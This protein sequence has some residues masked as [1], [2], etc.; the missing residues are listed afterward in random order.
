MRSKPLLKGLSL[1][2]SQAHLLECDNCVTSREYRSLNSSSLAMAQEGTSISDIDKWIEKLYTC[3]ILEEKEVKQL[4][5]KAKEILSKESNVIEVNSPIT[6]CGDLFGH[7]HDLL[8]VFKTGGK[9]PDTNYLFL[10]N[11]IDRGTH[12]VETV[13]LL[14]ALKIKHPDRVNLLRGNHECRQISKVYGLYDECV[15]KYGNGNVWN[16]FMDLF[17]HF[18]LTALIEGRILGVHGGLSPSIETLDE[19]RDLN[20]VQDVPVEGPICDLLWSDPGEHEG[21]V[22]SARGAGHSFGADIT[23]KFHLKNDLKVLTR[24]HKVDVDGH[25]WHHGKQVVSINSASNFEHDNYAA[26]MQLDAQVHK[27]LKFKLSAV[28]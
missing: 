23:A 8:E 25:R 3:Q 7:F 14:I 28:A 10:G 18:P 4:C 11:Y 1:N 12:S 19:I 21:F 24:S 16:F 6:V 22:K 9:C 26:I 20:R 13:S 15:K 2:H 5:D 17:D 27:F